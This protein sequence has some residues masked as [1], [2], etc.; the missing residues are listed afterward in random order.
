MLNSFVVGA[1]FKILDEASPGLRKILE[2]VRELNKAIT[3]T[4]DNLKG[5][6]AAPGLGAAIAETDSLAAAWIRVGA[7]ATAAAKLVASSAASSARSA[8]AAATSVPSVAAPGM[9]GRHRPGWL[10]GSGA[11]VTGPGVPIPGGSHLRL[12]GTPAMIGA[13][14]AGW[15]L[16]EAGSMEAG[17]HWLN[18]HL[19]RKD[20]K[21][22]NAQ[23]RKIIEEGMVSTGMPLRDIIEAATDEARLMK[24]T[25]GVDA[26]GSMPEFLR[27]ASAEALAKGTTLKESMKSIIGMAHMVKAY[28]P[29]EIKRLFP[30]FAYLSTA[31]PQSLSSMERAFSYAVPILQSGADV[32]PITTMLLGTGLS[33]AGVTN[34]KS[35]TW[36]REMV[37]R[38]MPGD[39][40]HNAAL[41]QL[42]LIDENEKP[43]WFTAGKPDPV[44]LLEIA[45]PKAAKIP[46]ADRIGVEHQV[47]GTQGSGAFAV[48]ADDKVLARI[49]ELRKELGSEEFANRYGTI[50]EDY[51][52][53][54]TKGMA[55]STL[56]EF[57]AAMI[58]LGT[59]GLPLATGALKGFS[60]ALGFFTGGHR[61][62]EDK[63]FKPSWLENLHQ[64]MPW[65]GA[66]SL[67]KPVEPPQKQSL[68]E[69]PL[70]PPKATQATLA[71]IALT[72][73]IDGA[74][75][76]QALSNAMASIHAFPTQAPAFD[77]YGLPVG[78]DQ[79][80]S[81]K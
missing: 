25:P 59:Q 14:L 72:L 20:S 42:G 47:F 60:T 10:G 5:L 15:G 54:T 7:E 63:T 70:A 56:G 58:E 71:P 43:T 6:G 26:V 66:S 24:G 45:G 9:G 22:N 8:A 32:D 11:H 73:N 74:T 46:V 53:G 77:G 69:G 65:S 76:A 2:S 23:L 34:T 29:A 49:K 17:T 1:T 44:K 51:T 33:T 39:D 68:L 4:R 64:L 50:L 35:G 78:G 81:D 36:L 67:P 19:G 28:T 48:L 62:Q 40:K 61:V 27:A 16:F 12:G 3:A 79:L 31:N 13:G 80:F 55:R 52:G 30:A 57:N 38:G 41:K 18:Y 37:K 75:I 21:E